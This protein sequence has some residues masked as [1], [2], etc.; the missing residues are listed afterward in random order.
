MMAYQ[1]YLQ[2]EQK[3]KNERDEALFQDSATRRTTRDHGELVYNVIT[4]VC[5]VGS[6]ACII[7]GFVLGSPI[8]FGVALASS[9]LWSVFFS[10]ALVGMCGVI[11]IGGMGG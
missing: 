6:I 4:A 5:V 2:R 7:A 9:S 11:G 3:L 1:T 10:M 8:M